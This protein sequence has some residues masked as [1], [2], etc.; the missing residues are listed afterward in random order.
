M[1]G[2]TRSPLP[3]LAAAFAA[4]LV[5]L[6]LMVAAS[7]WVGRA[8]VGRYENEVALGEL[9]YA[10]DRLHTRLAEQFNTY[11]DLLVMPGAIELQLYRA[12]YQAVVD[13]ITV[14]R[15]ASAERPQ[16]AG[17]AERLEALNAQWR[18]DLGP[19]ARRETA[20]AAAL[21]ARA[22]ELTR[23]YVNTVRE[24]QFA[25]E[26][27]RAANRRTGERLA[28]LFQLVVRVG[29]LAGALLV[30]GVGV[31]SARTISRSL[32][33]LAE[34]RRTIV[35]AQESVRREVAERLHGEV[36]GKLLAAE[37]Q[38]R[39]VLEPA[40]GSDP[41]VA[42]TTRAVIER[43]AGVRE[44]TR[45]VSHQLHPPILRM[46]LPAALRSLRDALEPAVAVQLEI[47]PEIERR[48]LRRAL[49]GSDGSAP[50]ADEVRITLYRLVQEA[51]NNAIRHAGVTEVA[52]RV[53]CPRPDQVAVSV[54][55][56]GAGFTRVSR[57]GLGMSSV[58]GA[59]EALGGTLDV[60]SG[61]GRGTRVLGQVPL[62][63]TA[64]AISSRAA[65]P[66]P[67]AVDGA[68]RPGAG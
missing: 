62:G 64:V 14:L 33:E 31:I 3:V 57:P 38:L 28:D 20:D 12:A 6:A 45:A 66:T 56:K 10:T 21:E 9:V 54:E 44:T 60:T 34:S 16:V 40:G 46:G 39:Q 24:Y 18:A 61:V 47:A 36:Q 25:V 37:M 22:E 19:R 27:L 50:F 15:A 43:L 51:T 68:A 41:A 67:A 8:L 13:Q 35:R 30:L 1:A 48:E 2:P 49:G 42:E 7:D 4:I 58:R 32:S 11:Q 23:E 29:G 17:P 52:V 59:L 26:E 55:D 53:W 63:A 5:I 65:G